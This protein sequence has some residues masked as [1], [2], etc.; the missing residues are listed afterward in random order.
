M[1]DIGNTYAIVAFTNL[2]NDGDV[3]NDAFFADVT[4]LQPNDIGV[5]EIISPVSGELLTGFQNQ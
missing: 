1:P 5:S 3:E 4:F 2:E